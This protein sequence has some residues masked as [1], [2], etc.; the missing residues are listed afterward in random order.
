MLLALRSGILC[1]QQDQDWYIGQL[2]GDWWETGQSTY[3][4]FRALQC[5]LVW[6]VKTVQQNITHLVEY[7]GG[8]SRS[9]PQMM[10]NPSS[11]CCSVNINTHTEHWQWCLV[12]D[13]W[14]LWLK[15]GE[16]EK[17]T[18]KYR[19]DR[20]K[21]LWK[22]DTHKEIQHKKV[23]RWNQVCIIVRKCAVLNASYVMYNTTAAYTKIL[24]HIQNQAFQNLNVFSTMIRTPTI[25]TISISNSQAKNNAVKILLNMLWGVIKD[26]KCWQLLTLSTVQQFHAQS[27][28]IWADVKRQCQ[29]E[30]EMR[31]GRKQLKGCYIRQQNKAQINAI[32][33]LS[34]LIAELSLRTKWHVTR[35]VAHDKHSMC[36]TWFAHDYA[37]TTWAYVLETVRGA[38]RRLWNVFE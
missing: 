7:T 4:P 13:M 26:F 9:K 2:W 28:Q 3:G 1:I 23:S 20:N 6:K 17:Q 32:S 38:V 5:H 14:L 15:D 19:Q 31:P 24:W 35:H 10:Q 33:T 8:G 25:Y 11:I 12:F 18:T 29:K 36:C 37:C 16:G 34:N 21:T 22:T 27:I 30:V